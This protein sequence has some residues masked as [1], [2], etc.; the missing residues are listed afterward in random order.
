MI[1]MK[2]AIDCSRWFL[3]ESTILLYRTCHAFTDFIAILKFPFLTFDSLISSQFPDIF[4]QLSFLITWNLSSPPIVWLLNQATTSFFC[5][6]LLNYNFYSCLFSGM[7]SIALSSNFVFSYYT[8]YLM[9][10]SMSNQYWFL[11]IAHQRTISP[12]EYY[13]IAVAS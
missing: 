3:R 2:G 13:N 12:L 4:L 9:F 8:F 5:S 11:S 6:F 1:F 10:P 7:L